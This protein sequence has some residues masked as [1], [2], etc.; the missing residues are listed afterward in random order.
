MAEIDLVPGRECGTCNA[1]CVVPSIDDPELRKLPGVACV[2]TRP[3]GGC[4]IYQTRPRTC[5]DFFCGWRRLEWVGM[6]LRPDASGV[7]LRLS[8]DPSL[9]TGPAGVA[10]VITILRDDGVRAPGL[11]R[12]VLTAIE[13]GMASYLVVPGPPGFTSCRAPLA[14][15]L[16]G[17]V[18]ERNERAILD[19]LAALYHAGLRELRET[20]PVSPGHRANA[21]ARP[22]PDEPV[23]PPGDVA[24]KSQVSFGDS[25]S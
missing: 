6:G 2:N 24:A 23:E 13:A 12:T 10:L 14:R 7:Y 15:E 1:C 25:S 3:D 20:R 9:A 21:A 19:R 16:A 22:I 18:R 4:A 8:H 11:A 5:R 17:P